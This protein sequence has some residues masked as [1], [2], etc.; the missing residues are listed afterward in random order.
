MTRRHAS[1]PA[2]RIAA[3][4]TGKAPSA[5]SPSRSARRALRTRSHPHTTRPGGADAV[6]AV[7]SENQ[8]RGERGRR[9]R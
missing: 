1:I 3:A 5:P 9:E 2:A 6:P 8:V 7:A 4:T